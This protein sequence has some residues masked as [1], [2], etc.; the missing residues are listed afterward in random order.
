MFSSLS[1]LWD[2][3]Y[4]FFRFL[5]WF[6]IST[7]GQGGGCFLP[8]L[9]MKGG[10]VEEGVLAPVTGVMKHSPSSSFSACLR[11]RSINASL[12]NTTKSRP[13]CFFLRAFSLQKERTPQ[14]DT[15]ATRTS[16]YWQVKILWVVSGLFTLLITGVDGKERH[17][18]AG[19]L[20]IPPNLH[21]D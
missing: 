8:C 12:N 11:L 13:H 16:L 1:A 21:W 20:G 19:N 6:T 10:S 14:V 18:E 5:L 15:L 7:Q 9:A 17:Q 4:L 2:E 3:Q